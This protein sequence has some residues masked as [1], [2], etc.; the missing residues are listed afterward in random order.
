MAITRLY[1]V[2]TATASGSQNGGGKILEVENKPG[3][4]PEWL[5][6]SDA[7]RLVGLSRT[8][9]WRAAVRDGEIEMAKIG[10]AVRLRRTSLE[11]Y[12]KRHTVDIPR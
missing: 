4:Q 6:Y 2:S 7:Q 10:T 9:L 1:L 5:S 8:S 12:M 3:I 11:A